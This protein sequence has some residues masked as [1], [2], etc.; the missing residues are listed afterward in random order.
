[1]IFAEDEKLTIEAY[2]TRTRSGMPVEKVKVKLNPQ[3]FSKHLEH[4]YGTLRGINSSKNTATYVHSAAE[5]LSFQL[6]MVESKVTDFGV[7][8]LTAVNESVPQQIDKFLKVCYTMN[9]AIH[10]PNF[11]KISWGQFVFKCKLL[12]L[13]IKYTSFGKDGTPRRAELTTK[14]LEDITQQSAA[15]GEGKSSPDLTHVI[16]VMEGDT[17]PLL[18]EKVYGATNKAAYLQVAR[19]NKLDNFRNLVTGQRLVFPPLEK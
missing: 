18:T 5:E 10:E 9:G 8:A 16:T 11:L 12:S 13:D 4:R 1:M 15:R 7:E 17:L 2:K 19:V 6:T 14:F 3:S